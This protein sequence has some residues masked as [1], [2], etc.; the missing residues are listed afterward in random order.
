ME[1]IMLTKLLLAKSFSASAK[2]MGGLHKEKKIKEPWLQLAHWQMQNQ[3]SGT[4]CESREAPP[5]SWSLEF[6]KI[7]NSSKTSQLTP[8]SS[9]LITLAEIILAVGIIIHQLL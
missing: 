7:S 5:T 2:V 4:R 6:C 3:I 9:A 1:N 8:P